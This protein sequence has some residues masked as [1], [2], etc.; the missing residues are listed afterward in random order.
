MTPTRDQKQR[1]T[2][3]LGL[4]V[5]AASTVA[6][7][8]LWLGWDTDYDIDPITQSQSG[9]Y[10]AWQVAGCVLSLIV[11]AVVGGWLLRP[12]T[13]AA[14]MTV[15]FTVAWSWRA[16]SVDDSGLWAVGAI[17]VF[18]GM[19]LGSA[20]LSYGARLGRD[21]ARRKRGRPRRVG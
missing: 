20:A 14:T 12:W 2:E 7:W 16:A 21:R 3:V 5:V 6:V 4:L 1:V 10:E 11:V 18:A 17:L 19:A 13:V 8:W 9:P 15:A